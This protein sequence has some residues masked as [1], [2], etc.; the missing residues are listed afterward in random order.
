ML[1]TP[2]PLGPRNLDQSGS[3]GAASGR[4]ADT[5]SSEREATKRDAVGRVSYVVA[6]RSV[7]VH[8]P[9][10]PPVTVPFIDVPLTCPV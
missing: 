4:A 7:A 2:V 3:A 1:D 6:Q 9:P 8:E 5:I 10:L